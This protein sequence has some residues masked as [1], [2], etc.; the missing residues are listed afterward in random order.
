M[1][2]PS[3]LVVENVITVRAAE[4][5][6]VKEILAAR[7]KDEERFMRTSSISAGC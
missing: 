4:G 7:E 2:L 5:R 3:E 1:A 6:T